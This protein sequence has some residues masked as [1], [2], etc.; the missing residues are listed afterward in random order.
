MRILAID[1]A[2]ARCSVAFGDPEADVV[3]RSVA[4]E[5]GHAEALVPMIE[6]VLAA[7]GA[8]YGDAE[9][10]AVIVGPG[11]FTGL[12]VGVAAARGIALA[13]GR[14]LVAVDT[15]AALAEA[16]R[17]SHRRQAIAAVVDARRGEIYAALF[18]ADGTALVEPSALVA[19]DF[20]DLVAEAGAVPVLTGSA[21]DI[22]APLLSERGISARIADRAGA[23]AIEA[24][25]RLGGRLDATRTAR[26]L[27]LR[28]PDAK[29]QTRFRIARQCS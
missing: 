27:Y 24:V 16:V 22:V 29:P 11:S 5:R 19:A 4:M 21:A 28:P 23:P 9:R 6:E 12:R 13:A 8:G 18:A 15:L 10:V 17:P 26:P 3:A 20:A 1:T 25:L 2:L 14:P 7:A